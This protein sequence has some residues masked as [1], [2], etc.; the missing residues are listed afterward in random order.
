MAA[1]KNR[2]TNRKKATRDGPMTSSPRMPVNPNKAAIS[3][4]SK[5]IG[6]HIFVPLCQNGSGAGT[7]V[8]AF[9]KLFAC[10]GHP[11]LT[12]ADGRLLLTE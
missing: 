1:P 10:L 12:S 4:I 3:D 11:L 7:L 5:N 9:L 6:A 2:A 8:E